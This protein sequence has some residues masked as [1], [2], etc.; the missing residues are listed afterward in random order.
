MLLL[1]LIAQALVYDDE[2]NA[3]ISNTQLIEEP[4]GAA[5]VISQNDKYDHLIAHYCG[6]YGVDPGLVRIVIEKESQFNPDALSRSGAMGLM[7]LMPET[8][9]KLGVEDAYDPE[10]NIR[11]GV[12]FL[13]DMLE[14]FNNN[15]ELA[16]A[17]YHAGP[18]TVKKHNKVPPIPET[19]EYV[20]YITTRYGGS[21]GT[22][23][24][25]L[26]FTEEGVPLITNR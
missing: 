16:L 24:I 25:K 4:G 22:A 1:M 13:G 9:E 6:L 5:I 18:A 7:Q 2:G 12:K 10:Q 17:A 14:M 26:T 23:D 11:G 20:D 8:A 3:V 19:V 21:T 15:I